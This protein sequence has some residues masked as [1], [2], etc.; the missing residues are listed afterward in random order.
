M[1]SDA[2]MV[3]LVEKDAITA[4]ITAYRLELLG[5]RVRSANSADELLAVIEEEVPAAIVLDMQMHGVNGL[6]LSARLKS[7]ERTANVPI[8]AFSDDADLAL[9]KRAY[10]A[11]AREF[12]VKP[13]DPVILEQKLERLLAS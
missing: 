10:A 9:V 5:Y 8:V 12:V 13:Y 11:G 4:E 6:E 3:L 1:T 2:A 7:A